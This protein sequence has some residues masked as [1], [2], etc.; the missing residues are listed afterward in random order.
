MH[1]KTKKLEAEVLGIKIAIKQLITDLYDE[2]DRADAKKKIV[3]ELSEARPELPFD[4]TEMD[5][6]RE[7]LEFIFQQ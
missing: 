6:L 2:E 7:T 5:V 1:S 3:V 4:D